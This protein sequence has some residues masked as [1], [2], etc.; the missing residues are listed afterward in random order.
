[1]PTRIFNLHDVL[2]LWPAN[3]DPVK[4]T[5]DGDSDHDRVTAFGVPEPYLLMDPPGGIGPL[6]SRNGASDCSAFDFKCRAFAFVEN[7]GGGGIDSSVRWVLLVVVKTPLSSQCFPWLG[8]NTLKVLTTD[9]GRGVVHGDNM[10]VFY[11]TFDCV[12]GRTVVFGGSGNGSVFNIAHNGEMNSK[13][14]SY[15]VPL[16]AKKLLIFGV[17]AGTGVT[18]WAVEVRSSDSMSPFLIKRNYDVVGFPLLYGGDGAIFVVGAFRTSL[19]LD[20]LDARGSGGLS[21]GD[22]GVDD[23]AV[24]VFQ[25]PLGEFLM[26]RPFAVRVASVWSFSPDVACANGGTCVGEGLCACPACWG[27][28]TCDDDAGECLDTGGI[29][30][31]SVTADGNYTCLC[32]D[33]LMR[34]NCSLVVTDAGDDDGGDTAVIAPPFNCSDRVAHSFLFLDVTPTSVPSATVAAAAAGASATGSRPYSIS[35]L[36]RIPSAC[37]LWVDGALGDVVVER[38]NI[39]SWESVP[40]ASSGVSMDVATKY[41]AAY[42]N[43]SSLL[44]D[45]DVWIDNVTVTVPPLLRGHRSLA[46][47]LQHPPPSG[48]LQLD[49][50]WS[51]AVRLLSALNISSSHVVDNP[52]LCGVTDSGRFLKSVDS[53]TCIVEGFWLSASSQSCVSCPVGSFC[54]GGE[55]LYPIQGF[56]SPS[57]AARPSRC[58]VPEACPGYDLD[59]RVSGIDADGERVVGVEVDTSRCKEGYH[60]DLCADCVSG[61]GRVSGGRCRAC[62]TESETDTGWLIFF[63]VSSLTVFVCIYAAFIFLDSHKLVS[64][65]GNLFS[66]Q[67]LIRAGQLAGPYV[68]QSAPWVSEFFDYLSGLNFDVRSARPGCV[69][70]LLRAPVVFFVT[71]GLMGFAVLF[72]NVPVWFR[73]KR[74]LP[75]A[76]MRHSSWSGRQRDRDAETYRNAMAKMK[77]VGDDN[78]SSTTGKDGAVPA[79]PLVLPKKLRS[80]FVAPQPTSGDEWKRRSLHSLLILGLLFFNRVL[81]LCLDAFVC[82]PVSDG[83]LA[84]PG[85]DSVSLALA[86]DSSS[87]QSLRLA[88]DPFVKCWDDP[89]HWAMAIVA[90]ILLAVYGIGFPVY[91][92][93]LLRRAFSSS[94]GAVS[95]R[96]Q[97]ARRMSAQLS[98]LEWKYTTFLQFEMIGVLYRNIR[99]KVWWYRVLPFSQTWVLSITQIVSMASQFGL[100]ESDPR[101]E[102]FFVG[103]TFMAMFIIQGVTLPHVKGTM[104]AVYLVSSSLS[105]AVLGVML[106]LIAGENGGGGGGGGDPVF[107]A[108]VVLSVILLLIVVWFWFGRGRSCSIAH[109]AAAGSAVAVTPTDNTQEQPQQQEE[110]TPRTTVQ[111]DPGGFNADDAALI[112]F[113]MATVWAPVVQSIRQE[114]EPARRREVERV[115]EDVVREAVEAVEVAAAAKEAEAAGMLGRRAAAGQE[116]GH[117]DGVG[118]CAARARVVVSRSGGSRM[119]LPPTTTA[120]RPPAVCYPAT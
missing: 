114:L 9:G 92:F 71:L 50:G 32:D 22:A 113:A 36:G 51:L 3:G 53:L 65:V 6:D 108:Y 100:V 41:L 57:E 52:S 1:M 20:F 33:G 48:Q 23:T 29:C 61:H 82:V 15:C 120:S 76:I 45:N 10:V 94:H 14:C 37:T 96:L 21:N 91:C 80:Q 118:G 12:V 86:S 59:V 31:D 13:T 16:Q 60:G 42:G 73:V 43:G 40:L 93:L 72:R 8:C 103:V 81:Q 111:Q 104:N 98:A 26:P 58:P 47:V 39:S 62:G 54:P 17:D 28:A 67:L 77:V 19:V 101:L 38:L 116:D 30:I 44:G 87:G 66:F 35:I 107:L 27:G 7:A 24:H 90:T 115:A 70:P 68:S 117:G 78:V 99:L 85:I 11:G 75:H 119:L 56:W 105:A 83:T 18:R 97:G 102:I 46:C 25:A 64:V 95:H 112:D 89:G 69:L 109:K 5:T 79:L 49:L 63:V 84:I 88:S 2:G 110:P 34:S 4:L 106:Y 74:V 55:I